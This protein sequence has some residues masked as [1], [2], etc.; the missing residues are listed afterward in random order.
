MFDGADEELAK[1]GEAQQR[2]DVLV[3]PFAG[4]TDEQPARQDP[5]IL[6]Q[7]AQAEHETAHIELAALVVDDLK[8]TLWRKVKN[9]RQISNAIAIRISSAD[10]F[11]A[12]IRDLWGNSTKF[13]QPLS[14]A[15]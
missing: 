8:Y 4:T 15:R 3:P 12:V 10:A 6:H 5:D 13:K 2:W 14:D 7:Q 1:A 9:I 11:I